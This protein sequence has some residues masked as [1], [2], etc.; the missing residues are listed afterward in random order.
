M[1]VAQPIHFW[2]PPDLP[3][4]SFD[5]LLARLLHEEPVA[6]VRLPYGDGHAWLATRYDDVRFVSLDPR[7][8][9]AALHGRTVTR[10]APHFIPMDGAMGIAD[11]PDHTRMRRVVSRAFTARKIPWLRDQAQIVLDGL[12]DAMWRDGPPTDLVAR[13]NQPFPMAM[14]CRL[15]GV[16]A[17]DRA[18]MG[19]WTETIMSAARG[20]EASEQ[21]KANMGEYY[22]EFIQR[23]RSEPDDDLTGVLAEAVEGDV[24]SLHEAVGLA[25]LIQIGGAHAV[26]NNSSNMVYALLTRP[27]HLARLRAEPALV[28]QAVEELLRY[29]PH[30]NAVGLPRIAME[31]VEVGGVLIPTGEAV[32]VSYLTANR[33]PDVF[34]NPDE[35]DFDRA[36]NPHVS[37]GYGPHHCLASTLARIESELLLRGLW[38]RFPTLRLAVP[39]EQ[40]RWQRGS[41]LR[42]PEALPV[43][44]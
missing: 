7:F 44:W 21:A 17:E 35:L 31:D 43:E 28:P 9:R 25:V 8:S 2:T 15:M 1:T 42:G 27:A 26:R 40:L 6:R 36:A 5:P 38:D 14:V 30:R 37:F 13:V 22:T 41:L 19:T 20:R 23:R 32:Y 4:L 24:L 11:P 3:G 12:L 18:A 39:E 10:L 34:A 33:D 29:I 16:P